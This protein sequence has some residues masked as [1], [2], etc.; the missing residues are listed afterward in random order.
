MPTTDQKAD[1]LFKKFFGKGSSGQTLQYFN[2]PITGNQSIFSSQVWTDSNQIPDVARNIPGVLEQ[3]QDLSLTA[4][5]GQTNAYYH[6]QLKNSIPFNFSDNGSYIPVLKTQTNQIIVFGQND[7]V[8]D[9]ATG[10]LTFYA[11]VPIGVNPANPPKITFW[12]YIG[13]IGLNEISSESF[14]DMVIDVLASSSFI[15]TKSYYV[16][17]SLSGQIEFPVDSDTFYL[18]TSAPSEYKILYL[19]ISSW[20]GRFSA[21]ICVDGQPVSGLSDLNIS[22][23]N[24]KYYPTNTSSLYSTESM[25]T[26][27]VSDITSVERAKFTLALRK[28]VD[29]V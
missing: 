28:S 16:D 21:S 3:I 13:R 5:P 7:W 17:D 9:T 27:V 15:V 19:N 4:I 20:Q 24:R 29:V 6:P 18:L 12:K 26:L 22:S 11:G 23:T 8:I 10:M 25:I 2:E 14:R 1:L